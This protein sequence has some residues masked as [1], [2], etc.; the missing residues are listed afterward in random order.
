MSGTVRTAVIGVGNIG[1][2]HARQIF[3]GNIRGMELAAL[4]DTDREKCRGFETVFPGVPVFASDGELFENSRRL[5]LDAVIVSV[6]H[7]FHTE[8]A[9]AAFARGLHVLCEKPEAVE[10]RCARRLNEIAARSGKVFGIMFNQRTE[11]LFARAREIIKS[12]AM[13]ALK[14]SSW[15]VTNW[16]RTQT[17]YD[18]GSWRATWDGE[19]GGVLIN[20]APHNLD[21]WIWMLGMPERVRGFCYQGKYHRIGV[22]DEATVFAEFPGGATGVFVTSTGEAPGTN[23]LEMAFDKGKIV[24][25]NGLL[26]MTE[27]S[28]SER[29]FCF[30]SDSGSGM[31]EMTV[32]TFSYEAGRDGHSLILENFAAAVLTGE[33][34]ISPGYDG[35]NELSVSNAAYLSSWTD[36]WIELPMSDGDCDVFSGILEEKSRDEKKK[37]GEGARAGDKDMRDAENEYSRRWSARW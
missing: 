22:E 33:E 35:V 37:R 4:C 1:S 32:R 14:R 17:Y 2:I 9:E 27:L 6:P 30:T 11:P 26:T 3:A 13:G 10:L 24:L 12:G 18:S 7:R 15:T 20:Q 19:G 16:Y 29:D 23:R 21:L 31:P 5:G 8:I 36:R 34:L 28:V 25:E